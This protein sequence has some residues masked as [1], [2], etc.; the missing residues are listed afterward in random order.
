MFENKRHYFGVSLLYRTLQALGCPLILLYFLY[1]GVTDRRYWATFSERLGWLP[2]SFTQIGPGAIWL[3]AVSVGETLASLDFLRKLRA[4]L[5]Q[6]RIF[7]SV[8]T[9]AG[10]ATANE[11]LAGI[12]DG[13]FYAPVDFA[14]VVRRVLRALQPSVV[15]IAETEIWPNLFREVK[16]TQAGLLIVNGR[17]SDRAFPR[18]LR[19]RWMFRAALAQVDAVLAQSREMAERFVAIGAPADRVRSAGNFKYDF[20]ARAASPDSPVRQFLERLRPAN[21]WIAAST[22]PPNEDEA[23]VAAFRKLAPSRPGLLLILAPRKPATFDAAA[24]KLADIPH[25]RRSQLRP[26]DDLPLPGVL[27]LDTIGELSGLFEFADAVFMGGTLVDTGGHNILEP[28]LFGKPVIVGPHMENFREIANDFRA[29]GASVEIG[30]AEELPAA[31]ARLLDSPDEARALGQRAL[32]CAESKRGASASA[33]AEVARLYESGLPRYRHSLPA[34]IAGK[35]LQKIWMA[36]SRMKRVVP[37]KLDARVISIGNLSMGGTGKTPCVLHVAELLKARGA[38]PGILTR[39]HGRVSHE[40]VLTLAPGA[41]IPVHHTGDEPQIFLRA[42][43]APVGIASDRYAAGKAL[44]A[45]FDCDTLI[46]DD[47]FQHRALARDLDIVLLDALDPLAGGGVFPLGRLR[48]PFRAISR[49]GLILV[50][51]SEFSDLTPAIEREV[52]NWNPD[53]PIFRARVRPCAWVRTSTGETYPPDAPPFRRAGAFCGLGNPQ[54]FRRTLERL[55]IH[56]AVWEEFDDHHRYRIHEIHRMR[57]AFEEAGA[58][59]MVTT[60]KDAVNL[61]ERD[62]EMPTYYLCIAMEIDREQEF[63]EMLSP[64]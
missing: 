50:T 20:E 64:S 42:G 16:R 8:S 46:L 43:V 36:G 1:R 58:E 9:L 51:R 18:Y 19:F 7:V 55:G 29:A 22:M 28:A 41:R 12:A 10:R 25:L 30:G 37:K 63:A 57:R 6:A 14:W 3:H 48:Q 4:S 53:A 31:V 34:L 61:P 5:P 23:V 47:G 59:A 49:A 40:A 13:V 33:V 32:A 26:H 38:N 44:I 21:V 45:A 27:L 56:P 15:V 39:G 52:R 60:E 35:P 2:R 24:A 54:A 62:E 11:K 17:V